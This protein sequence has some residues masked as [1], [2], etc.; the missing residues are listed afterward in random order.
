MR[1]QDALR[2]NIKAELARADWKG[3]D[4]AEAIGLGPGVFSSR[5]HGRTEW[6]MSE[7]VDLA[8]NLGISLDRLLAGVEAEVPDAIGR[9]GAGV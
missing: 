6:R 5:L 9:E 7:L 1:Y 2:S 4:A 8:I 3:K